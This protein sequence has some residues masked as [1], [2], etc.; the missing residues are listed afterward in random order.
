MQISV[1][2]SATQPVEWRTACRLPAGMLEISPELLT[3]MRENTAGVHEQENTLLTTLVANCCDNLINPPPGLSARDLLPYMV[4]EPCNRE[5]ARR[6][7]QIKSNI[8]I[9]RYRELV[10]MKTPS[11]EEEEDFR[12]ASCIIIEQES[13]KSIMDNH[14][15]LISLLEK[16]KTTDEHMHSAIETM[17]TYNRM[18]NSLNTIRQVN[19]EMVTLIKLTEPSAISNE[20]IA[21]TINN[22]KPSTSNEI[23]PI[24]T[25]ID[26]TKP[27]TSNETKYSSSF[28]TLYSAFKYHKKMDL[29]FN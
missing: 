23:L 15:R 21:T 14:D 18:S 28:D 25:N 4:Y 6:Y 3:R 11:E 24:A 27:S 10:M 12:R 26:K 29:D 16:M 13:R 2:G 1:A 9:A 7:T 5:W 22:T 17:S 19:T 8:T 20:Q